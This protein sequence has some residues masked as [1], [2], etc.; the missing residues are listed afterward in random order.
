MRDARRTDSGLMREARRS[1]TGSR[2]YSHRAGEGKGPMLSAMRDYPMEPYSKARNYYSHQAH[3]A[4]SSQ[5]S[6][7]RQSA[8]R[9]VD[10]GRRL[11]ASQPSL[12]KDTFNPE[13]RGRDQDDSPR[14]SL[15][16]INHY[17]RRIEDQ[18]TSPRNLGLTTTPPPM[19]RAIP[20]EAIQEARVEL[21]E[22][23]IQYV[24]GAD[25]AESA[26][27]RERMRYAEENDET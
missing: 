5:I 22:I 16:N 9:W 12:P 24:N 17:D 4:H 18:R 2:H 21:R 10:S 8:S 1:D 26:A 23:M 20:E 15:S 6:V 11:P 27:R 14:G 25:P 19:Q 7:H 3:S 13:R